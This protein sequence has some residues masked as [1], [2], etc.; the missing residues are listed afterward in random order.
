MEVQDTK[1]REM[2]KEHEKIKRLEGIAGSLEHVYRLNKY[3][4]S[5]LLHISQFALTCVVI[6]IKTVYHLFPP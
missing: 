5:A 6:F 2:H 3:A 4:I 1:E